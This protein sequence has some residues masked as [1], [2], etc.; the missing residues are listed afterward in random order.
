MNNIL[1][2]S[3]GNNSKFENELMNKFLYTDIKNMISIKS[4]NLSLIDAYV[5]NGICVILIRVIPKP[6]GGGSSSS[7]SSSYDSI[8]TFSI[9]DQKYYPKIITYGNRVLRSDNASTIQECAYYAA[10]AI[11]GSG[12]VLLDSAPTS[13]L[14]SEFIKFMYPIQI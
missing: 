11:G 14:C 7:G 3:I 10:I 2:G 5:L 6:L 12:A 9:N 4:Q 8:A 13:S 1:G